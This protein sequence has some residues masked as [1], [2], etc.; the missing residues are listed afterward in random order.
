ME[1]KDLIIGAFTNYNFNQLRPWV[2]SIEEC[3]FKGD[4]VMVMGNYSKETHDE[5]EKRNFFLV[6]MPKLN[7]PVHVLRFL[8]IYDYL[9]DVHLHY[10]YV[11]TTD[12]KDVYFQTNPIDWLV[13]NLKFKKL[14]AGSEG[15]LYKDE[16]WGNDNLFQTYGTYVHELF[17]NNKIYNVGTI[18]G[19]AEYVKDL[20]FNIFTNA[21][22]RPI[23][24][25]D[26]AVYNVLL[27]TQPY[28]D[29]T[30][31]AD[32]WLGWACQAGT[33][34]DPS[35]IN[36]FRPYLVEKEPIFK[37]GK[38]LTSLGR[39]FSIVHQ[40]D[41]VPEWKQF[42]MEKYNQEDQSKFFTYRTN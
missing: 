5:L 27:Q 2:E 8:A 36:A 26:Q 6:D 33:T 35:K 23:P 39:P 18:G 10:R 4:K 42:V 30:L 37:D 29:V 41:R 32:Q 17:K 7:I 12:V 3:G 20:V 28:K 19:D 11:V 1:K 9:K 25:V 38:V 22:N 24:I 16:P 13:E 15:M 14:V 21:T 40:Y 34:V 31:F